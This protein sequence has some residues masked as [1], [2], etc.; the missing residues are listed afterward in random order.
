MRG[1]EG[2]ADYRYFPDPDLYPLQ[3]SSE[4]LEEA[5]KLP[6]LPDE[7]IARLVSAYGLRQYDAGVIASD[8]IMAKFFEE[9]LT[10]KCDAKL[11]V[12]WLT[13]ELLGRL[14]TKSIAIEN[15]P[16]NSQK[17]SSLILRMMDGTISGKA[18]KDTLDYV[19]ENTECE[20]DDAIEKLGL[21][22]VSDDGALLA[23]IEKVMQ[24]NAAQVTAYKGG[25]EALF[26]FFVGQTM[27]LSKGSANPA[28][29]NDL[30]KQK[31]A[32]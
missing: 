9:L 15:S 8:L 21:K 30:L 28:K 25:K 7:K 3:P 19:F 12:S 2:S 17:L 23:I 22:Q 6:E 16:V 5:K 1:K 13:V 27:K 14:N 24:D 10:N 32:E 26:G 11:A 18:A 29:V 4:L 20:I 31:L